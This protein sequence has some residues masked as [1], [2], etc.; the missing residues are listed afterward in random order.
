MKT[1]MIPIE[2][3]GT[4]GSSAIICFL[5]SSIIMRIVYNHCSIIL[6]TIR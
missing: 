1:L 2:Y 5:P 6:A 4:A 3:Y